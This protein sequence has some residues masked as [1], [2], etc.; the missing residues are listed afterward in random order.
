MVCEKHWSLQSFFFPSHFFLSQKIR[1][2]TC[3]PLPKRPSHTIVLTVCLLWFCSTGRRPQQPMSDLGISSPSTNS[4]AKDTSSLHTL[5]V[6]DFDWT[7]INANSDE[8]IPAFFLGKE[9]TEEG[10][11]EAWKS[12]NGDWHACVEILVNR[13]LSQTDTT[14]DDILEAAR[15]MPYLEQ[16]KETF[17][18]IQAKTEQQSESGATVGQMILSDGNTLFIEAFCKY[19]LQNIDFTH[20]IVSNRGR[21]LTTD[22][23]ASKAPLEVVHYSE[24]NP[25]DCPSCPANLC[26]TR[27]LQDQLLLSYRDDEIRN[28]RIVY[29]GDGAN[30]ACPALRYLQEQDTLLARRGKRDDEAHERRGPQNA[31]IPSG[32]SFGIEKALVKDPT[33]SPQYNVH[34]WTTGDELKDLVGDLL[35]E[36]SCR[37]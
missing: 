5:F 13:V 14:N 8:Y 2:W 20:G 12:T 3:E 23:D 11:R 28:F 4:K 16:V 1:P 36:I 9:A 15:Q 27:A 30:D 10:L 17:A 21:F 37:R 32:G 29:V 31:H 24:G 34:Y 33:L 19:S 18:T 35:S 7:V 6:W 26:K 25:H 22:D